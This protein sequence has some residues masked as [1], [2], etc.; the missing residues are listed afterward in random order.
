MQIKLRKKT[1]SFL[2]AKKVETKFCIEVLSG[3]KWS[4]LG[5][6]NGILKF[7]TQE[8][9]NAKIDELKQLELVEE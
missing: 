8:E 2:T 4:L 9:R 3:R 6:E 7:D 1:Q 5:D